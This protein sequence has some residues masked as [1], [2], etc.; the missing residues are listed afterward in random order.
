MAF[1]AGRPARGSGS[2][3]RLDDSQLLVSYRDAGWAVDEGDAGAEGIP[4][5]G[6]RAPDA[7][8][9]VRDGTGYP[10]R[11]HTLLRGPEPVLL[12][13]AEPAGLEETAA[14][15]AELRAAVPDLRA[16]AILAEPAPSP[17]GLPTLHDGQ[18]SF[19][20]TYGGG[21]GAIWL[22][23]P[24]GHLGYRADRPQAEELARY[25]RR[26]FAGP[27]SA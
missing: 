23:R 19:A 8:G 21:M 14:L 26:S 3:S 6:D 12:L 9:L 20:R 25:L 11:L 18:G 2:D 5:P 16:Y 24:D 1:M 22:V 4:V 10:Q 13:R 15:V 27:A 7:A 17:P